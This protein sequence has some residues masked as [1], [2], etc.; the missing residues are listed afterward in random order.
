VAAALNI[1]HDE[2]RELYQLVDYNRQEIIKLFDNPNPLASA[3]FQFQP[4]Q[5]REAAQRLGLSE[6]STQAL[7]EQYG[8]TVTNPIINTWIQ[9]RARDVDAL[10]RL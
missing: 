10:P 5:L 3:K 8:R 7:Y 4:L 1:T 6:N 9:Q 2:A